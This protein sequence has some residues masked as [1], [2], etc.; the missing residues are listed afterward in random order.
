MLPDLIRRARFLRQLR[1]LPLRL[2]R[3]Q[4]RSRRNRFYII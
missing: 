1:Y 4:N 3:E 2:L